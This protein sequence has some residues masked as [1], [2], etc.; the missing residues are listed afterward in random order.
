MASI[1]TI[2]DDRGKRSNSLRG[3]IKKAI[4]DEDCDTTVDCLKR[5]IKRVYAL[6]VLTNKEKDL[7]VEGYQRSINSILYG[8]NSSP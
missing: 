2:I 6:D 7:L 8:V 4:N 3:T 1:R 5:D